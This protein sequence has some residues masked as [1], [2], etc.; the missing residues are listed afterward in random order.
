MAYQIVKLIPYRVGA[1]VELGG[2]YRWLWMAR[3]AKWLLE[4]CPDLRE[5]SLVSIRPTTPEDA[6][7]A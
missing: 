1:I 3:V 7:D 6:D 5:Y 2:T 4:L